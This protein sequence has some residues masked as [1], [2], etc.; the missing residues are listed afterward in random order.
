MEQTLANAGLIPRAY[1]Q[2]IGFGVFTPFKS[3]WK[4]MRDFSYLMIVLVAIVVGFMVMFQVG[5]DSKAGVTLEA[6]L[7]R[8]V[9]VLIS[10]SLS[11][12]LAGFFVDIM[13]ITIIFVVYLLAP[14]AGL[15]PVSQKSML[16]GVMSGG[17]TSGGLF[18]YMV[19]LPAG[20]TQ[21]NYW[22]L[23][24]AL[25]TLVPEQL[26]ALTLSI[27]SAVW[28]RMLWVLV[29]GAPAADTSTPIKG[30]IENRKFWDA[31]KDGPKT[32]IQNILGKGL[33]APLSSLVNLL[34]EGKSSGAG[35]WAV[36]VISALG[37][38]MVYSLLS[39]FMSTI[40]LKFL[41]FSILILT[42]FWILIRITFFLFKV[43]T[44]IVINIFAAP[45]IMLAD[46][47]PGQSMFIS[48]TKG[49]LTNLMLFPLTV[50]F[51]LIVRILMNQS[52][53]GGSIWAP[54]FL[55]SITDMGSFIMIVAG[56]ILYMVPDF[57]ETF[58]EKIG[59]KSSLPFS[60]S[61]GVF[62]T[63]V[64][65]IVTMGASFLGASGIGNAL[66][67]QVSQPAAAFAQKT[68]AKVLGMNP[69]QKVKEQS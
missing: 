50:M 36:S 30:L 23:G 46:I 22:N 26:Q 66:A 55:V 51:F 16:D 52:T 43:Y 1:A 10:I 40:I 3:V 35:T 45:I 38:F 48:W 5:S 17:S 44:E 62:F 18:G 41:I 69:I 32:L 64:A 53:S 24:D 68:A 61:P 19:G 57:L 59:G 25:W 47:V 56:F 20:W 42:V 14:A 13:Y 12:A 11:Y 39:T 65:P 58:K 4:V 29:G 60:A 33:A 28:T 7:P 2:G 34:N 21:F 6:T 63:G 31:L 27:I 67:Q 9:F 8:I 54:P 49:M 37:Y 15:D